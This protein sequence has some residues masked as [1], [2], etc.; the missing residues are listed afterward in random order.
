MLSLITRAAVVTLLA[1]A[2][3]SYAQERPITQVSTS[4][5]TTA[6]AFASAWLV[7]RNVGHAM[8]YVSAN[9]VVSRKCDLPPG[10]TKLLRSPIQK[11]RIVQLQLVLMLK[12]FPAYSDVKDAIKPTEIPN[13]D[14]FDSITTDTI[15]LLHIRPGED[16]YLLC[17]FEEAPSYRKP[18]L[19]ANVYYVGFR[20]SK[21]SNPNLADWITAWRKE[22]GR[23]RLFAIGLLED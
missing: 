13:A 17:K 5:S 12:A 4:L 8:R 18:L 16:G 10:Q 9:P 2:T 1:S 19:K 22:S 7:K 3:L 20:V 14:W 6:N 15:Q 11:R 23:W 21:P